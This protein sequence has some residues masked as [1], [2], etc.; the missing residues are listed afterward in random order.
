MECG[1]CFNEFTIDGLNRPMTIVPCGHALCYDCCPK[2]ANCPECTLPIEKA[3]PN[4]LVLEYIGKESKLKEEHT[5]MKQAL[6]DRAEARQREL[7]AV[8]T[9]QVYLIKIT[10]EA[11]AFRGTSKTRCKDIK[12]HVI[13]SWNRNLD[14]IRFL[15]YNRKVLADDDTF[16][17]VNIKDGDTIHVVFHAL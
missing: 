13:R 11:L 9:I 3:I 7:I 16:E 10:G 14:E 5:L 15:V 17:K 1:V 12:D 6:R 4:R 2:I 8:Q